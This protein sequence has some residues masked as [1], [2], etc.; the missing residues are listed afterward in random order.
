L[1][2]LQ[3]D[4]D[5]AVNLAEDPNFAAV[6]KKY[7]EKLRTLQKETGDPWIMKWEYE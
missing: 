2:D 6:L 7:Q 3:Q 1:Y 5:E 4:P